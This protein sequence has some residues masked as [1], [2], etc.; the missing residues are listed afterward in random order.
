MPLPN[1][2]V[3][4]SLMEARLIDSCQ[5]CSISETDNDYAS[6]DTTVTAGTS[7]A[8]RMSPIMS[9]RSNLPTG[10]D[11]AAQA[12]VYLP[13][14]ASVEAGNL[15]KHG[16][17]YYPVFQVDTLTDGIFTVAYVGAGRDE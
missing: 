16:G 2:D 9:R 10:L 6:Q 12:I 13:Y 17:A 5:V 1:L 14:G 7:Y 8:C 11:P 3:A 4:R 15:I